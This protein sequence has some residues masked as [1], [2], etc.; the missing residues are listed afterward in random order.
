MAAKR[1]PRE[2]SGDP[3]GAP[4][5]SPERP[6]SEKNA[7]G[8]RFSTKKKA[9]RFLHVIFSFF[10]SFFGH[11]GFQNASPETTF[12]VFFKSGDFV[13]IVLPPRK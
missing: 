8:D 1:A 12:S 13:K 4:G 9:F 10:P 2:P 5:Q 3:K 11:F 7:N 6:R